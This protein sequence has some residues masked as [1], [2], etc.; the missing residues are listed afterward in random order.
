MPESHSHIIDELIVLKCRN[1]DRKAMKLLISK[2]NPKVVGLAY[3]FTGDREVSNDIAQECWISILRNIKN[4]KDTSR[5]PYWLTRIVRNKSIDWIRKEKRRR[6]FIES[7]EPPVATVQPDLDK[8]A[9]PVVKLRKHIKK[10]PHEQ[11]LI[12]TMHYLE[13]F[14]LQDIGKILE[15]PVGTVKSRLYYTRKQLLLSLKGGES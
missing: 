15:I 12:L 13:G 1:G 8:T 5:F 10:L 9:D 3:R 4:L 6:T 14:G 11:R 2:W 7:S